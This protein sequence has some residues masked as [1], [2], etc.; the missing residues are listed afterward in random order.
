[1]KY[2]KRILSLLLMVSVLAGILIFPAFADRKIVSAPDA[3]HG[4]YY[5]DD[6]GCLSST[7]KDYINRQ[8]IALTNAC[9]GQ[10]AVVT[11]DYLNDL[12]AEQYARKVFNEWGVGDKQTNNG[13]VFVLVTEEKKCWVVSGTGLED[14]LNST[15]LENI[16]EQNCYDNLDSGRYDA[17][18]YDTVQAIF[19]WYEEYYGISLANYSSTQVTSSQSSSGWGGGVAAAGRA[20]GSFFSR[21]LNLIFFVIIIIVFLVVFSSMARSPFFWCFGPGWCS[22][23]RGPRG[24][25]AAAPEVPAGSADSVAPEGS[26]ADSAAAIPVAAVPD[27]ADLAAVDSAADVPEAAAPDED[28]KNMGTLRT[29][30]QR[31]H[32]LMYGS[33]KT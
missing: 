28:N 29:K 13:T 26:A 25:W 18:V 1:M 4:I 3:K 22:G 16:L 17:A 32:L 2:A 15:V 6:A 14:D 12:D 8:N 19:S 11:L 24:P 33:V 30:S 21:I 9:G 7:T 5:V 10:V 27:A 20:V 23:P 31:A